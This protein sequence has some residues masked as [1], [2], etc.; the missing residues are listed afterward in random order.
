MEFHATLMTLVDSKSQSIVARTFAGESR[1]AS[2]PWLVGG[3]VNHSAT[4]TCLKQY[5]VDA[6]LL[7]LVEDMA[8]L[9]LLFIYGAGRLGIRVRP[10]DT[11]YCCEPYGTYFVF[12]L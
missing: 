1:Q 9:V 4:N 7:Q 6:N 11:A 5:G 8:K 12:G 3:R 2:I 10:V